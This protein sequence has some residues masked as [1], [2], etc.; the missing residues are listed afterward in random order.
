MT[1]GSM[2][3]LRNCGYRSLR[4][5]GVIWLRSRRTKRVELVRLSPFICHRLFVP[6]HPNFFSLI[7]SFSGDAS[8]FYP[9]HVPFSF[10]VY[11]A[12]SQRH[13]DKSRQ[14]VPVYYYLVLIYNCVSEVQANWSPASWP[15]PVSSLAVKLVSF[16][17]QR[18]AM[19]GFSTHWMSWR[20][21]FL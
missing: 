5:E 3:A 19:K 20:P 8:F 13:D 7:F 6:F 17:S 1:V 21:P 4:L 10:T 2:T 16:Q 12:P 15:V 18:F 14:S 11:S 9:F